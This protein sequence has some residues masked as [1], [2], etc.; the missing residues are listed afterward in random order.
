MSAPV[1]LPE[2]SAGDPPS[3]APKAAPKP[4]RRPV[5]RHCGAALIDERMRQTGFCCSGCA[6]VYRLVHEHGLAGYYD[7]KDP[8]TV[9]ADAAVFHARDYGWLETA[10]R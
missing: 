1:P 10:Q 5:C 2:I 6:Y 4:S 9:P 3:P 8:I 7:L